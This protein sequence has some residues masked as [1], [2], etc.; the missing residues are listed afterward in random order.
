[1]ALTL[2]QIA[3]ARGDLSAIAADLEFVK[4]Q[5]A[6]LPTRRELAQTALGII[7]ASAALVVGWFELFGAH[8]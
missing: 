6:R 1:M 8:L 3:G 5:L 7:V 2:H 4:T